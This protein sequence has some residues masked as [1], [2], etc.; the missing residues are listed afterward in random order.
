MS[1]IVANTTEAKEVTAPV[2]KASRRA[3]LVRD[4]TR[5]SSQAAQPSRT[6]SDGGV[7]QP[8]LEESTGFDSGH[9]LSTV[10]H[11]AGSQ[12]PSADPKGG[13]SA[14]GTAA[15]PLSKPRRT[16]NVSSNVSSQG[17]TVQQQEMRRRTQSMGLNPT[18][19]QLIEADG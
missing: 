1:V 19:G 18:P 14:P 12:S 8:R 16:F 13:V 17:T 3:F 11:E 7:S 9:P 2:D 4:A 10:K 5:N 15:A 6:V